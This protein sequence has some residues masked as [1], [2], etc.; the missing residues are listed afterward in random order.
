MLETIY[1]DVFSGDTRKKYTKKILAAFK[2]RARA[3]GVDISAEE[4]VIE[5]ELNATFWCHDNKVYQAMNDIYAK[6]KNK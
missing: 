4:A 5:A 6:M 2:E 3:K 1:D